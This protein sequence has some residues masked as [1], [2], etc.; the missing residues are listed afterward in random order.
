MG[1]LGAVAFV[2]VLASTA[3]AAAEVATGVSVFFAALG[4]EEY[5]AGLLIGAF[6]PFEGVP[7]PAVF[8]AANSA[9]LSSAS[10]I[11]LISFIAVASPAPV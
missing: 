4:L 7:E 8:F 11:A 3:A 2:S 6:S 9:S 1:A 10:L 5:C